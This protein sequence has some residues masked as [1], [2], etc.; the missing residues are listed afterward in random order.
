MFNAPDLGKNKTK[1]TKEKTY[2]R[3]ISLPTWL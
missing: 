2:S 1:K 3:I